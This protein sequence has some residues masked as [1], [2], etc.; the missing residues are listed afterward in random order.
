MS[1]LG[2]FV[3]GVLNRATS[4]EFEH[5]GRIVGIEGQSLGEAFTETLSE[6]N[7]PQQFTKEQLFDWAYNSHLTGA[8]KEAAIKR[9]EAAK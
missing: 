2:D 4:Y 7:N 6:W 1:K 5:E 9:Y 8:D 3:H